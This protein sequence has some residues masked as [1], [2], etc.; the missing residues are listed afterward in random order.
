DRARLARALSRLSA[1]H[2]AL[3]S[4]LQRQ[5]RDLVQVEYPGFVPPVQ[6]IVCPADAADTTEARLA[7]E[8]QREIMSD[9]PSL[10]AVVFGDGAGSETVCLSL[11]HAFSD[12]WSGT[13]M[14]E[15]LA[16]AYSADAASA[17][18]PASSYHDFARDEA[19]YLASVQGQRDRAYWQQALAKAKFTSVPLD[20]GKPA[21]SG[22]TERLRTRFDPRS[23][24]QLEALAG[25][26]GADLFALTLALFFATLHRLTG[27]FQPGC[28]S[29][30]SGRVD[31]RYA[32]CVGFFV[33]TAYLA[34]PVESDLTLRDLIARVAQTSRAASGHQRYPLHLLP[35]PMTQ[36]AGR[37][38]DDCVFQMLPYAFDAK[39]F[40]PFVAKPFLPP[41]QPRRFDFELTVAPG[42]DGLSVLS[43][44]NA[45]RLERGWVE[46]ALDYYRTVAS[47]F[48]ADP[49]RKLSALPL[50]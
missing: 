30:F 17:E 28:A 45:D 7:R 50:P 8:I 16:A 29:L 39:P 3:R 10:R 15:D 12:G 11:H 23:S 2:V 33:S 22:P 18:Q 27:T 46:A 26:F 38:A 37:R 24:A 42:E 20:P 21:R 25:V 31:N 49:G 14:F 19:A 47:A 9:R 40:G 32:D 5:R 13:R 41:V 1:R 48:L 44:W 34:V 43:T 4:G 36:T 6:S 35:S